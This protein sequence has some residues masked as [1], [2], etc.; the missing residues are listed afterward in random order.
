MKAF[1]VRHTPCSRGIWRVSEESTLPIRSFLV[2]HSPTDL[3]L[4]LLETP[5]HSC[6]I[7]MLSPRK[8]SMEPLTYDARGL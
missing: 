5:W 6:Y 2:L 7:D 8:N 1:S 3:C 4:C